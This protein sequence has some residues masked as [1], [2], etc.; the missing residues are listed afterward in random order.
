ML[1][2]GSD[3]MF[4]SLLLSAMVDVLLSTAK[5]DGKIKRSVNTSSCYL[6][7]PHLP[8]PATLLR[9][10]NSTPTPSSVVLHVIYSPNDIEIYLTLAPFLCLRL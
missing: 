10:T 3:Y 2:T 9:S 5:D 7:S 4:L 1:L 6:S 8:L